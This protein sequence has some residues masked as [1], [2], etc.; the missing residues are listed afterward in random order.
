MSDLIFIA[1]DSEKKAEEVR[2][3]VLGMQSEYLIE[4]S[5]AVIATRDENGR[6]KLNQLMH[7][8]AAG[9]ASG[10]LWGMLIGWIFLMPLAGA[11]VGAASGALGGSLVDVG[12]NDQQMKQ[13]A[14]DALKPGT[15]GLFLLIRK[16]TTDKVL[17]DQKEAGRARLQRVVRLLLHLLVVDADVD[18]RAAQRA[19]GR[20]DGGA[21]QWHEKDP[22]DQH[23]PER[24]RG[25]AGRRRMHELVE[26]DAAV[27]VAGRNHRVAHLDQ[28]L[29][30]HP[31]NFVAHF[32]SLFLAVERYENKVAHRQSPEN[33][34]LCGRTL[35]NPPCDDL[36]Q[37]CARP[38]PVDTGLLKFGL[39]GERPAHDGAPRSEVRARHSSAI[40][41]ALRTAPI[42]G[43]GPEAG[44]RRPRLSPAVVAGQFRAPT[45]ARQKPL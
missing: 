24:A 27:F 5:D 4:V 28:I 12:I 3:K 9:A 31:E 39:I 20:A 25:R 37:A 1:F 7:P 41:R 26:L 19:R 2:D 18:E 23:A 36:A 43:K 6:V 44:V 38:F 13:Q 35:I 14:N 8:A 33:A 21:G 11:A 45:I 30:L 15:A 34:R 32:L 17:E 29:A 10:A 40:T 16:M 22:A 42:A